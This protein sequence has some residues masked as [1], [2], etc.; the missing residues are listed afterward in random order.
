MWL[1]TFNLQAS[2]SSNLSE[3][4]APYLSTKKGVVRG[5]GALLGPA[6]SWSEARVIRNSSLFL[7]VR[8]AFPDS[9]LPSDIQLGD[10]EFVL[11]QR[12]PLDTKGYLVWIVKYKAVKLGTVEYWCYEPWI[13]GSQHAEML[14][15]HTM[16]SASVFGDTAEFYAARYG[17]GS[18]VGVGAHRY[19]GFNEHTLTG[20][21]SDNLATGAHAN[22][23]A[24]I[25]IP[26]LDVRVFPSVEG[27]SGV[28][29]PAP[30]VP[31]IVTAV[32]TPS[33][34]AATQNDVSAIESRLVGMETALANIAAFLPGLARAS[35]MVEMTHR[36]RS[37]ST[38]LNDGIHAVGNAVT[39]TPVDNPSTGR[40]IGEIVAASIVA[41][42]VS[43][44]L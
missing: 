11:P 29:V 8:I 22:S 42:A 5:P 26:S 16:N 41:Q 27:G 2:H 24:E 3:T 33:A 13:A 23:A 43:K 44:L 17:K 32:I 4:V 36:N 14:P 25:W 9:V 28:V 10:S 1:V 20:S 39:A 40:R 21:L 30:F 31:P 19:H 34:G 38:V 15:V 7:S 18:S 37:D 35:Q 6:L 12:R